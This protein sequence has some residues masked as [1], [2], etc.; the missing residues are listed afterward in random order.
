MEIRETVKEVTVPV[1]VQAGMPTPPKPHLFAEMP[2][3]ELLA[4]G[5]PVAWLSDVRQVTEDSLLVLVH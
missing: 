3:E 2:D 1:Y 4:Y 5:V